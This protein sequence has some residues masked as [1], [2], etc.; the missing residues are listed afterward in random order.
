MDVNQNEV[1]DGNQLTPQFELVLRRFL[2]RNFKVNSGTV[3]ISA[4]QTALAVAHGLGV[5]P[6]FI[7]VDGYP[8]IS[9]GVVGGAYRSLTTPADATYIYLAN[10]G[11]LPITASWSAAYIY[12]NG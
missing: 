2:A 8:T 6:N 1:F 4:G 3:S 11:V 9:G 12:N 5:K 10:D 7:S